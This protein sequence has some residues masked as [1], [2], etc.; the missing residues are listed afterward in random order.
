[1]DGRAGIDHSHAALKRIVA[2]LFAM[3][4]LDEVAGSSGFAGEGTPTLPRRIRL[5]VLR[6]LRPAEAAA[7][8]LI[9]ALA[10]TLPPL[11]QGDRKSQKILPGP[12][13]F[14]APG[15]VRIGLAPGRTSGAPA[16]IPAAWTVG[17][18]LLDPLR[19]PRRRR[20]VASSVPRIGVPGLTEFFAV[21]PRAPLLPDDEVDA[22]RLHGRLAALGRALDDLPRQARRFARW[23]ERRPGSRHRR[24]WPLRPGRPPG[25]RADRWTGN[26][27][28]SEVDEVLAHAHGLAMFALQRRDSS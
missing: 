28:R 13:F 15:G 25:T 3:A 12:D 11:R 19:F 5:A 22:F 26:R 16:Q 24:V 1:M 18:A 20:V 9:I 17:F 27:R 14:I 23:Q 10:M 7:R 6:L 8:R 2:M 4:G 21:L